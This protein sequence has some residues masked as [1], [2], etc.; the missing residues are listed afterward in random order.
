MRD[1][2]AEAIDVT[3]GSTTTTDLVAES[4]ARLSGTL[5]NA[6]GTP[7][8]A[9]TGLRLRRPNGTI[10]S[11]AAST[12]SSPATFVRYARPGS[13]TACAYRRLADPES[14]W[15]GNVPPD[16]A[17]PITLAPAED[18]TGIAITLP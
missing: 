3:A 18:R 15:E 11:D 8:T 1:A 12:V 14:C 7:V 5:S 9:Q 6:D 17:T 2:G 16:E 10:W 4:L 13:T